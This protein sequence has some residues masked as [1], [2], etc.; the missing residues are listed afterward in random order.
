MTPRDEQGSSLVE[1][2]LCSAVLFMSLFG[3]MGLCGALYSYIFVS[4]AARDAARYALV[5]GSACTGFSDCGILSSQI[6]TYVKNLVHPGI[7]TTNLTAAASWSG[8][9]VPI[10]APGNVVTVT[11]SY[12][13]PLNI[14]FWPRSGSTIHLVSSSQ[15]TV[16]Q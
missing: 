11:V 6:N 2:A 7:N 13:F 8:S 15:M 5:R 16:S 4:E 12:N 10:N 9:K 3:V 14:P 1:F